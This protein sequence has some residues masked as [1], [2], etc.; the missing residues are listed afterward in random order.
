[1]SGGRGTPEKTPPG[2]GQG[3]RGARPGMEA[4]RG[5]RE[6]GEE[7]PFPPDPHSARRPPPPPSRAAPHP[8]PLERPPNPTA[9]LGRAAFQMSF[10][11]FLLIPRRKG[12]GGAQEPGRARQDHRAALGT[13]H[14]NDPS[15]G[16]PTETLSADLSI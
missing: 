6:G 7:P 15:A 16:S 8:L 11:S 5:G 1:R 9:R 13:D 4:R 10:P 3:W 12:G 14:V 2:A